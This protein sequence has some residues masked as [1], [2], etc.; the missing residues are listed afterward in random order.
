L[1]SDIGMPER[2]GYYLVQ[3]LRALSAE[4]GGALPAIALTAYARQE[5]AQR[6]LSAG[7]QMHVA[8]PFDV[9]TLIGAVA[10]L[11]GR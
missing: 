6:A 9:R 3:R 11:L 2:D 10:S 5:D 1:I 7:Y 8:K 4:E